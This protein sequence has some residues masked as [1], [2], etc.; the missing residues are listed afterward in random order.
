MGGNGTPMDRRFRRL[1]LGAVAAAVLAVLA[2]FVLFARSLELRGGADDP[3]ADG[4][5]VLTGGADR[6]SDGLNLL[7]RG[8]GRRLFISGVH[9]QS[10]VEALKRLWP[11]RA[12]LFD[13]CIDLDHQARNTRGNAIET[14]DWA[15]RRG[16]SSLLL[17]TASYHMP[18]AMIEFEHAM[19]D[20]R[21]SAHP[22]IPEASRLRRWW[23]DP[24]LVRILALEFAK[25][26][27]ASLRTSLRIG[28]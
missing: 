24:T 20:I 17:V 2:A 19:P 7:E 21:L 9:A 15:R 1:I 14:R 27:A 18:R 16:F 3:I 6:I 11:A 26:W 28:G 10:G 23:Q 12:D 13:C 8:K 4:I 5:V 22:V 25:Y